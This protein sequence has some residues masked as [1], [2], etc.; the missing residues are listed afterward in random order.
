MFTRISIIFIL[1]VCS[2]FC[3]EVDEALLKL[4]LENLIDKGHLKK[5]RNKE[6]YF[7]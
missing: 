6:N 3:S 5:S 1:F 2:A 7:F 4:K